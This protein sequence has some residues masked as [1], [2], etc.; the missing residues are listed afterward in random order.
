M[1][2]IVLASLLACWLAAAETVSVEMAAQPQPHPLPTKAQVAA[3]IDGA[4]AWLLAQQQEDGS[5]LPG[6]Q[7]T[8]GL[9][10]M[11]AL[12]LAQP[13]GRPADD[14]VL[15]R[16]LG[17]VMKRRQSDGGFYE[18]QEGL[19]TYGT[20]LA[21]QLLIATRGDPATIGAARDWLLGQQNQKPGDPGEGGIGHSDDTSPGSENLSTT[22]FALESLRAS[23][24]SADDPRMRKALA[25]L[26]RCQKHSAVNAAEWAS[27][28]EDAGSGGGVYS[29][30]DAE[31]AFVS[32]EATR[33][34]KFAATGGMTYTL[35]SSY[36]TLDLAPDDHRVRAALAFVRR[37]YRFDANPGMAAGKERQGLLHYYAVMARTFEMLGVDTIQL[38]DGRVAD[39]R[40]D[41]FAEVMR[42]AQRVELAGGRTG[43]IWMND[44]KRWGEGI[45]H[46][47]TVYM[48]RA[49][50]AVH[51]RVP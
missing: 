2:R 36:L 16:A 19:A 26:E 31:S 39:W 33:A 29:P 13:P 42:R 8:L 44:A 43:L 4:Q 37:N 40:A 32:G 18:P 28:G 41:L 48:L 10:A 12:A 51:A 49:L 47:A 35:L 30:K 14:P 11:T 1:G 34:E 23:G 17:Y 9:T 5:W 45:P 6:D 25:F 20:S 24:V 21:L 7:F 22:G 50:K 15:R 38:G 46:L 27:E 3:A